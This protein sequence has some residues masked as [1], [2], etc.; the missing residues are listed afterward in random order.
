MSYYAD[1]EKDGIPEL[2]K[3]AYRMCALVQKYKPI[4]LAKWHDYL[5]IIALVTACEVVCGLLPEALDAF[6]SEDF[7]ASVP[8]ADTGDISGIDPSAPDDLPPDYEIT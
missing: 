3:L 7:N 4:I 6:N 8:P 1:R 2:T 5:P